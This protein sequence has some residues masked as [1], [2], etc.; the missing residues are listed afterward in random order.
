MNLEHKGPM[1]ALSRITMF[2]VERET[3]LGGLEGR[4]PGCRTPLCPRLPWG[5]RGDHVTWW[6]CMLLFNLSVPQFLHLS[7]GNNT[8]SCYSVILS[9]EKRIDV[10][11]IQI[12]GVILSSVVAKWCQGTC[13]GPLGLNT[14]AIQSKPQ[15]FS[16]QLDTKHHHICFSSL[17]NN[18]YH[19]SW[20]WE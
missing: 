10:K 13:W 4:R 19:P 8:S 12:E 17:N 6:P 2:P 9:K 18:L 1:W 5:H 7:N 3:K 11:L 16:P 20:I 14:G 15:L